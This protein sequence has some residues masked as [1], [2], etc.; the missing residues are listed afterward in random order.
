MRIFQLDGPRTLKGARAAALALLALHPGGVDDAIQDA[1]LP[2][3]L[4]CQL[5]RF[6]TNLNDRHGNESFSFGAEQP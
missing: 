5:A 1:D 4:A 2:T 3:W 6:L